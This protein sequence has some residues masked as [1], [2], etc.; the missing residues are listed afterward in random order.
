MASSAENSTSAQY[1][2][3]V[4]H[5]RPD[6]LEALLPRDPQLVFEV[7]VRGGEKDVDA[8]PRRAREGGPGAI[9]VG[10]NGAGQ[11]R[12][13]RPPH[14]AGDGAHRLEIA[15]GGDREPG[16]DDVDAQPI[17]LQRE[18]QFFRGRHAEAW[19]LL[20]IAERGVEDVDA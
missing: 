10:R 6:L 12:D 8:G 1:A 16:L 9:D 20:A 19:G 13:D 15:V 17:E 2:A 14:G 4:R 18:M 5:G 3:R 7:N 11:A